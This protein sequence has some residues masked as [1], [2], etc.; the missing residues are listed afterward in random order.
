MKNLL[1]I[2]V[3]LITGI[4]NA[5]DTPCN[6]ETQDDCPPVVENPTQVDWNSI[7]FSSM[8]PEDTLNEIV[9]IFF[10]D[11]TWYNWYYADQPEGVIFKEDHPQLFP[12]DGIIKED[13]NI[14]TSFY[15]FPEAKAKSAGF[16]VQCQEEIHIN[17]DLWYRF[18]SDENHIQES[19]ILSFDDC[20]N[21]SGAVTTSFRTVISTGDAKKLFLMYHELGHA[22]LGLD[23][24]CGGQ[25][26]KLIM[27]TGACLN[28]TQPYYFPQDFPV[29]DLT[30]F[31]NARTKM[32][33]GYNRVN[34]PS[35]ETSK[36]SRV[37][38]EIFN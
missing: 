25:Y 3:M 18:D 2:L 21:A 24:N 31:K 26:E 36:G 6:P 37:I 14:T 38:E 30:E 11:L 13:F 19:T 35:C 20:D 15:S 10:Q 1:L 22:V 29:R 12:F 32:F 5:Q 34:L 7:D 4:T 17:E 23:H 16:V 8:S 9:D 33:S 28:G 27:K